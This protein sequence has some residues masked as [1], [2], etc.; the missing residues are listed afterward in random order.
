M[1]LSACVL[2]IICC[3]K[4]GGLQMIKELF[5]YATANTTLFSNISCGIPP[6]DYFSLIRPLDSVDGPPWLGIVGMITLSIWY[7]CR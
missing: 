5:P 6:D 2:M 3:V 7:F 1:I 4:V